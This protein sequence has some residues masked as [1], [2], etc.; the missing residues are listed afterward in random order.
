[1]SFPNNVAL[2]KIHP[3]IGI[4][5]VSSSPAYFVYGE[6]P[7][8][9]YKSNGVIKR[10]AVRFVVVGY[11][12][13]GQEVG[14][15][16]LADLQTMGL[17]IVWRVRVANKKIARLRG[18]NHTIA[19]ADQSYIVNAEARSD[20]N[21]GELV[22][23]MQ[24]ADF[25]EGHSIPLGRIHPDGLFVPGQG[26]L[27]RADPTIAMPLAGMF[28][29]D[30][31][32]NTCDGIVEAQISDTQPGQAI[33]QKIL[34]A[35]LLVT[36]PDFAPQIKD[37]DHYPN[38]KNLD[39]W[40][41]GQLGAPAPVNATAKNLDRVHLSHGTDDFSPGVETC[42]GYGSFVSENNND[43]SSLFFTGAQTLDAA[44]M[45]LDPS[46]AKPGDLTA[47]MCSPWQF[48]FSPCH[49]GYWA[50][51]RPDTVH[52]DDTAPIQWSPGNKP[53]VKWLRYVA[54]ETVANATEF[55]ASGEMS[56]NPEI[57]EHVYKL[58]IIRKK[59]G[60][61]TETERTNDIPLPPSA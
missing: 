49:C 61:E 24:A 48:D 1:M 37:S 58:G 52:R 32:D 5:R 30:F 7:P 23:D 41:A 53:A 15:Y 26:T 6:T 17:N 22:G 55:P 19:A 40:L 44:D 28:S 42:L 12:A 4:A 11:D 33:P 36:P 9:E 59:N 38:R 57:V 21:N 2:L 20:Q 50:A 56:A 27:Y 31:A 25:H 46:K 45:R 16:S 29:E 51:H 8:N 13:Q 43:I 14:A 10:Q 60:Q 34:S 54:A 3:A 47:Y 39:G 18:P 35:W